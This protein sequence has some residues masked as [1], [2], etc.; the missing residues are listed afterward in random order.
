[1]SAGA[2]YIREITLID[3]WFQG[4]LSPLRGAQWCC[5]SRDLTVAVT[6]HMAVAQ[7][8]EGS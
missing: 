1:M 6:T 7:G 8:A 5:G 3:L 4:L 2:K